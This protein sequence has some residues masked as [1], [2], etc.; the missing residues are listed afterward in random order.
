[1]V[2]TP[3]TLDNPILALIAGPPESFVS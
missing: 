1:M 2:D 3:S